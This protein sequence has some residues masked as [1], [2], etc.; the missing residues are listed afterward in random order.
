MLGEVVQDDPLMEHLVTVL[1]C[2]TVSVDWRRAPEHPYPAAIEDCRVGLRWV[3]SNADGLQ[4]DAQRIAVGGASSG[5]GL[6]AGLVLLS[7]DTGDRMP[8]FQLLIYPMLDDR[9]HTRS[10]HAARHRQLWNRSANQIAWRAYLGYES[11]SATEVPYYAAPARATNLNGLPATFIATGDL[12]AFLDEDVVYAQ[13]LC[14]AN[15]PLEL[16]VYPGA[17]HGFDFL[18]PES[19]LSRQFAEDRDQAIRRA[20]RTI[21]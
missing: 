18:A 1:P 3:F 16:H 4:I 13:R 14:T 11:A 7:R 8:C 2:V 9:N 6:A 12:D 21:T 17:F 19:A 5:G 15:V 10:S 20:F